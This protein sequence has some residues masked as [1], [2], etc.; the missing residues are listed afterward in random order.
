MI[1]RVSRPDPKD[2]SLAIIRL[3]NAIAAADRELLL[4]NSALVEIAAHARIEEAQ[5]EPAAVYF[6]ESGIAAII[7]GDRFGRAR[8]LHWGA[9]KTGRSHITILNR[10]A[11][12]ELASAFYGG[13]EAEFDRLLGQGPGEKHRGHVCTSGGPALS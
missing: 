11:L 3:L 5:R 8:R 7:Y 13:A 10:E 4:R 9:V 12:T 6:F 1:D 2:C